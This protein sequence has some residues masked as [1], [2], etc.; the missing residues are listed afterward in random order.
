[1]FIKVRNCTEWVRTQ[2]HFGVREYEAE[3]RVARN[4]GKTGEWRAV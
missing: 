2:K 3:V 4:R 1:M